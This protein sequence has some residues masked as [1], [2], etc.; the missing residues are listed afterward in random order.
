[1]AVYLNDVF[2]YIS[3]FG[4]FFF[5]LKQLL[6]IANK[7]INEPHPLHVIDDFVKEYGYSYD[8]VIVYKIYDEDDETKLN[9]Y[10]TKYNLRTVMERLKNAQLDTKCFYSCQR[11]EVYVKIRITP[12]R[13]Q[14]E[15]ARVGYRLLLDKERLR[16]KLANGHKGKWAPIIIVDEKKLSTFQPQDYIHAS[17]TINRKLDSIWKTYTHLEDKKHIFKGSDRIKLLLTIFEAKSHEN[18]PGCSLNIRQMLLQKAVLAAF[19]LH[20]HDELKYLQKKWLV[21]FQY[22]WKQPIHDVR[23]YFGERIGMY[24]LYLQHYNTMLLFI[25]PASITTYIVKVVYGTDENFLMPYFAGV[26][27][28]WCIVFM[29]VRNTTLSTYSLIY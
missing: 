7:T 17:Y 5:L 14:Q 1:M 12:I 20:D 8:Y 29:E 9:P 22:P 28:L 26:M 27:I 4:F 19:P 21:L 3:I 11:D 25:L 2:A 18:P 13:L 10:Q 24:F 16:A 15:A 23:D 6:K